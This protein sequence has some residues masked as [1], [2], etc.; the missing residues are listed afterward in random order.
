MKK[1]LCPSCKRGM[2]SY[3]LDKHSETCPYMRGMIN[4]KCRFYVPFEKKMKFKFF[5]KNKKD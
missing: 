5:R 1:Q 3:E 2:E 4:G